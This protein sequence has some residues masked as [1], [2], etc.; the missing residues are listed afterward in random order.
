[1]SRLFFTTSAL[2]L[3][4]TGTL[5][6]TAVAQDRGTS[7]QGATELERILVT[8]PLRRES[9]LERS[10]SSVTVVS[11][12]E[13]KQSAAAD[14]TS[15]LKTYAGV[16]A[17]S[18][19][20]IGST[21]GVALRGSKAEQTLVL[22]NGVRVSSA[23][24]G[25]VSLSNIPLES[26]ERIEIAKG[27]HSTQYGAD[28]IG[29][30]INIITKGGGACANGNPS[31]TTLTTGVMHPWGGVAS[32]THAGQTAD[33]V[34]YFFGGSL[35]GTRGFD[36]TTPANA[37]NEPDD[38]GFLRGSFNYSLSKDFDWGR[39]YSDGLIS[40]ARS[41]YDNKPGPY[42]PLGL[43]ETDTDTLVG[44]LGVRLDH[45]ESWN[46]TF[47]VNVDTDKSTNFRDGVAAEDKFDST[48]YGILALTEK[49]FQTG[50]AN[51]VLNFGTEFYREQIDGTGTYTVKQRDLAALF[52]QYSLELGDLT[53]DS[54]L[55][56]DYN[57]QFGDA[58]TYNVGASYAVLPELTVRAS[59]GTGFRAP[60]FND[61][62][63]QQ[64]FGV[65][66][67]DLRPE[68][69][70]SYEVGFNWHPSDTTSLDV[71]LYQNRIKDQINWDTSIYPMQPFN[72]DRVKITG[73]EAV[74]SHR[75]NERWGGKASI[76]VR[77]PINDVTGNYVPSQD[78]FKA[79][80][81]VD[82]RATEKLNLR[83]GV[84]YVGMRYG[85][86]ANTQKMPAYTTVDFTG[87]YRLDE[88]S[89]LKLSVENL[90]NEKYE[91]I[92][93]YNAMGRTIGLN[94]SRTF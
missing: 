93:G 80:V 13:I 3:T 51:H 71:A 61:L 35:F 67:P 16:S 15:L 72:L 39:I 20:G 48:R 49:S 47:E 4:L 38:D 1:M 76:D 17:S 21:S 30:I 50:Q 57:E 84:F 54:G 42:D 43:N 87:V 36:F 6:V 73:L 77:K 62:Y 88:Q 45:S 22:V 44:K 12:E 81:E 66:N 5:S 86:A 31:C 59:Y 94:F 32:V 26:I 24:G 55:R 82:F 56:Y 68:R 69:S 65:G 14:L 28:A 53:V 7:A 27:A 19:G 46:S 52:G 78:R 75:F 89:E 29:G 34:N 40:R 23:T 37:S 8:T 64:S 18:Y 41:Q 85:N 91:R 9:S 83:A 2:A 79:A 11:E 70:Q 33:G 58:T 74:L 92:K 63:F 90:F 10:T 60:S 25:S